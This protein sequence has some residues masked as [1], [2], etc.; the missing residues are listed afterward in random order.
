MVGYGASLRKA[1]R[2]GW[3]AAY[4]EYDSLKLL[5]V[6]V[7]RL[8]KASF[9]A[10][11]E[12]AAEQVESSSSSSR[13]GGGEVELLLSPNSN[14]HGNAAVLEA[15]LGG[16][17]PSGGG[18]P[19]HSG[20]SG[21]GGGAQPSSNGDGG[22]IRQALEVK[23][24]EQSERFLRA[25]RKQVE[26]V[27]LFAL[28]R[29]GELA[30]AVGAM[31]F[32]SFLDGSDDLSTISRLST[33]PPAK[34]ENL[35]V[36]HDSKGNI[37]REYGSMHSSEDSNLDFNADLHDDS[38]LAD[39]LWFLLPN[40]SPRRGNDV[41]NSSLRL[42]E[43][44]DTAPRP[45]FTGR[46]VL[47]SP[48]KKNAPWKKSGHGS[49]EKK[50]GLALDDNEEC[51]NEWSTPMEND[52][53]EEG[54]TFDPYTLIG[55]ELLHLLRFICVNAMVSERF[56]ID[57]SIVIMTNALDSSLISHFYMHVFLR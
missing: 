9:D 35:T 21:G 37:A 32:N 22:I 51:D 40:I 19:Y 25:L 27:S 56:L 52:D 13:K 53:E 31:R 30:D 4:L 16:A 23:T 10:E 18:G 28:S 57:C 46:A 15:G 6:E 3:S 14:I 24:H 20:S 2:A 49:W 47:K 12:L 11:Q 44:L 39:D 55:V 26:K 48:Q 54:P 5:L 50:E 33:G 7:E 36:R 45:L 1:Q 8:Y 38:P 41:S 34:K 29:Q 43:S 17:D 42:R